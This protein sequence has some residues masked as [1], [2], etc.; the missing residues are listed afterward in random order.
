MIIKSL[1]MNVL[2]RL[3]PVA[4]DLFGLS[5]KSCYW[6][7]QSLSSLDNIP[8]V[9]TIFQGHK[10]VPPDA[11]EA[12][13]GLNPGIACSN[14]ATFGVDKN[15]L[16][17]KTALRSRTAGAMMAAQACIGLIVTCPILLT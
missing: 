13:A 6:N 9:L 4:K 3:I 1:H 16:V 15:S 7:H 12:N 14:A 2:L 5:T 10:R 17:S 8:T 11:L